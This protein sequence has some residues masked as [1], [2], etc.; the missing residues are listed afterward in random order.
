MSELDRT[1][2][3][4]VEDDDVE[5]SEVRHALVGAG[6][7]VARVRSGQEALVRLESNPADLVLVSLLLPDTDG[8]ML[9]SMLHAQFPVPIVV[10]T[11]RPGDVD[12]ALA[13]QLGAV[14]GLAKPVDR[15]ELLAQVKAI[16]PVAASASGRRQ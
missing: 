3:L 2:I 15:D 14:G 13:K 10:L 8:L 16:V 9:C 5:A 11:G 1:T 6:Y 12:R 7:V 4:V